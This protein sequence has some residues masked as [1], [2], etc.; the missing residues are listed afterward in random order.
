MVRLG[1]LLFKRDINLSLSVKE[2]KWEQTRHRLH[3]SVIEEK[4]KMLNRSS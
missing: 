2:R 4:E 1:T 3:I